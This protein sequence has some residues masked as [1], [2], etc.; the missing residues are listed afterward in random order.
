MGFFNWIRLHYVRLR[1]RLGVPKYRHGELD[2]YEILIKFFDGGHMHW[3]GR[4]WGSLWEEFKQV[5]RAKGLIL[6][7]Y[8]NMNGDFWEGGEPPIGWRRT[9]LLTWGNTQNQWGY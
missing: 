8:T 3:K 6:E 5:M 7:V 2:D 9:D 1:E 4:P